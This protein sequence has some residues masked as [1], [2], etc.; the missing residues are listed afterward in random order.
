[1]LHHQI[2]TALEHSV[3]AMQRWSTAVA[4][5]Q[6][7]AARETNAW[8]A[9]NV[10]RMRAAGL[11][12]V[13]A[14]VPVPAER[15]AAGGGAPCG[16]SVKSAAALEVAAPLASAGGTCGRW[17]E[18][19]PAVAQRHL[20]ARAL[21]S[22]ATMGPRSPGG[23][24]LHGLRPASGLAQGGASAA[25]DAAG[26]TPTSGASSWARSPGPRGGSGGGGGALAS[27]FGG[28]RVAPA[29][30]DEPPAEHPAKWAHLDS[31]SGAGLAV[32]ARAALGGDAGSCAASPR[33]LGP[34]ELPASAPAAAEATAGPPPESAASE[35]PPQGAEARDWTCEEGITG[36]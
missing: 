6:A 29:V 18:P 16:A 1:V 34:P 22:S 5:W 2:Y 33:P 26:D 15:S 11:E 7:R 19:S 30:G 35:R 21:E 31:A 8:L 23:I 4:R 28:S 13:Y 9:A 24:S 3:T 10:A 32:L 25:A 14:P 20:R 27:L 17:A 12:A 36:V